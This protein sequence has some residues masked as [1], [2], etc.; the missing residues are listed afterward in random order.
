M[1]FDSKKT[2]KYSYKSRI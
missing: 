1:D 2:W